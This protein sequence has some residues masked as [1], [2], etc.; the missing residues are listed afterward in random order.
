VQQPI[1][2]AEGPDPAE[3][4]GFKV[5]TWAGPQSNDVKHTF[6][7]LKTSDEREPGSGAGIP[8]A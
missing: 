6:T 5:S 4:R 2:L 3:S 7:T 8:V 1:M